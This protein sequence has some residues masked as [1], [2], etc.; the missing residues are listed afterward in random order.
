VASTTAQC[1]ARWVRGATVA[2]PGNRPGTDKSRQRGERVGQISGESSRGA[3][4]MNGLDH[5]VR[6]SPRAGQVT[7]RGKFQLLL[8][9][10]VLPAANSAA[11]VPGPIGPL[12]FVLRLLQMFLY[13][14]LLLLLCSLACSLLGRFG[15]HSLL[16]SFLSGFLCSFLHSH[17][18]S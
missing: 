11:G 6:A 5:L 13:Y 14:R 2:S 16:R 12:T 17:I 8:C 15:L 7:G 10:C 18:A 4:R 3:R 1:Y 9:C